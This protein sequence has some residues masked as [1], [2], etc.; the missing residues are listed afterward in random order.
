MLAAIAG[1]ISAPGVGVE[2]GA[3]E[4]GLTVAVADL[5]AS[6]VEAF[7][8]EEDSGAERTV[9]CIL[10]TI[11]PVFRDRKTEE[12]TDVISGASLLFSIQTKLVGPPPT[13]N[14]L[15]ELFSSAQE[16]LLEQANI[17]IDWSRIKKLVR[18]SQWSGSQRSI[19]FT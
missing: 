6:E 13:E 8:V 4:A 10:A 19:T 15:F 14:E 9:A 2:V 11:C 7:A 1:A 17:S 3:A 16:R 12:G 18:S 5:A